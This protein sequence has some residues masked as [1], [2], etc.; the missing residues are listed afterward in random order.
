MNWYV[1]MIG[2]RQHYAVPRALNQIG[3]LNCFYTD[4]WAPRSFSKR[5]L[6]LPKM[7]KAFAGRHHVGLDSSKVVGMN[8]WALGQMLRQKISYSGD[9]ERLYKFYE[10]QGKAFAR[11]VCKHLRQN[12]E[13][14]GSEGFFGF[15]STSLETI[16]WCKNNAMLTVVDQIDPARVEEN[17]VGEEVAAWPGWQQKPERIP[18]HFMDRLSA[19]WSLADVVLVNSDWSRRALVTQGVL[20]DKII[21]VPLAY[22]A[23]IQIDAASAP[24]KNKKLRI[25][26]LGSVN[27]RKGIPYLVEAARLL[28]NADIEFIVAGPMQISTEA[29]VNLPE[30]V[31]FIGKVSRIEASKHYL[32]A[33]VFILPTLSDGFAITQ[34]EAMAHGL[35]VITTPNCGAVVTDG[36]DGFIVPIRDP[37]AIA[38]ALLQLANDR[39]KLQAMSE[40]A[41]IKSRQ[42]T[43]D[44]YANRFKEAIS[45]KYEW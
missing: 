11:N 43:L 20:T 24:S 29:I 15:S 23:S 9:R 39:G 10:E 12:N 22:E 34:L 41:K 19:E 26:W 27:L 6:R 30:N 7:L 38:N 8:S 33:D 25:L 28:K 45:S 35:P 31:N 17:I 18:E 40:A 14:F 44:T 37:E 3:S 21:T 13:H 16:E 4:F 2:A 42:F 5:G 1:S 32:Q 36:V